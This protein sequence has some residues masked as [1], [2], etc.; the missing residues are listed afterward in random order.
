MAN[1]KLPEILVQQG[2][3]K[4]DQMAKILE[5][6]KKTGQ[7][8]GN[9]LALI[10]VKDQQILR[11][12]EKH[13][14]V[15]GVDL[16][17]FEIAKSI[18]E[19]IPR[20][21]CEKFLIIPMQKA[22]NTLVVAFADPSNIFVRDDLTFLTR[23]KIQ[24]VV[25]TE[26][27]ISAAIDK[28][29][30]GKFDM[31]MAD[32]AVTGQ[33][34]GDEFKFSGS[35]DSD[36]IMD[37]GGAGEEAP[38]VKFV[39]AILSD[40]IK[41]KVSDIHFEPYEKRYRVRFRL[42]GNLVEVANTPNQSGSAIASRLKIIAKLDIAEKRRPQDGRIKIK[43]NKGKEMDFRVSCL[44]TLWGEKVVLRLLDKSNLQLDM[45]KLGF[46][47]DDLD[48]FQ[49][50]IHLPQ[51]LILITGPTGSGKTTTI[52]SALAELNQPDV[53]ISTA[54]DPVEFNLEG[55]NQVQMNPDIDLTFASSLKSFL[56]QD[57]DIIMVGEIRDYDTAEIAFKASSTGHLVVS[58]LH[59]NDA[60]AT[61]VRLTEMG[62]APYLVTATVTLIVAQRLVGKVC[63]YCK[64]PLQVPPQTLLDLG[65]EPEDVKN[66]TLFKGKG[67][68]NCNQT[69]IK[70]RIA[71]YELMQMSGAIKEAILKGATQAELRSMARSQGMKTLRRSALLK[72]KKGLTTIEEVLNASVKDTE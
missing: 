13:F 71:I 70:G 5:D 36:I 30:S 6:Q 7:K 67:C 39:N 69:G 46:E 49:K 1:I 32:A 48:L 60:P 51:G 11:A 62:V 63:E 58:T 27:A 50:C 23:C 38:I 8:I 57:P 17:S 24:A 66:Y 59:T 42:D 21:T 65:V 56:R 26:N 2:I 22:G 3:V 25:A 43:T 37:E 47:Q 45:T 15:P 9:L 34:E 4:P 64:A 10:G 18:T 40:A 44:P 20:E 31:Q 33:K 72:L 19:L 54:E 55:I 53:N 12:V 35:M 16:N 28:Y 41:K 61:V 52:Y 29:Y 14:G 68:T